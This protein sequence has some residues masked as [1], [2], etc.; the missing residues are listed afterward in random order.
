MDVK[1]LNLDEKTLA[2]L[3]KVKVKTTD[4]LLLAMYQPGSERLISTPDM[5]R[6]EKALKEAG[7][8]K[9]MR[10]DE[11]SADDID[12]EPLTWDELHDYVGK[13]IVNDSSTE[14]RRYLKAVWIYRIDDSGD[15]YLSYLDGGVS[16]CGTRKMYI[17]E[18]KKP[19]SPTLK[20]SGQFFVLK[21]GVQRLDIKADSGTGFGI[22]FDKEYN[23]ESDRTYFGKELTYDEL[24]ALPEGTKVLVYEVAEE[25]DDDD[26]IDAELYETEA[27]I[28]GLTFTVSRVD[29]D[30]VLDQI[31]IKPQSMVPQRDHVYTRVW[32]FNGT[33]QQS[34]QD[35]PADIVPQLAAQ[36]VVSDEYS[37]AI[38]LTR[39]II[40]NGQAAQQSLWE[41][42]KG[43]A[44][45]RDA[46]LYKEIGYSTF[47]DYCEEEIGITRRQG[48][49]YAAIAALDGKSTSDFKRIGVEKL[50][51]LAKIDDEQREQITDSVDVES[52]TVRELRAQIDALKHQNDQTEAALQDAEDRAQR[53]CENAEERRQ[54][55]DE[56]GGKVDKQKIEVEKLN[57]EV[58]NNA[59]YIQQLQDRSR[60]KDA[61]IEQLQARI[62]E[63]ESRPVEVAVQEDTAELEKLRAEYE[64]K[65]A[66]LKSDSNY[67]E[68]LA[69]CRLVR[70]Q[71]NTLCMRLNGVRSGKE[72]D[73]LMKYVKEIGL[74]IG[75]LL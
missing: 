10:G 44:E 69:M 11:V 22:D 70:S 47:E 48:Q 58:A 73:S 16:F 4:Q 12:P 20:Y 27:Q 8:I 18:N 25:M 14:S 59:S 66:E 56:L 42:C 30:D 34:D 51:L 2:R 38:A 55:I 24:T 50:Y 57:A 23:G 6:A 26:D 33:T 17:G 29:S 7:I 21:A 41:M 68:L 74:C 19:I 5:K 1:D 9:Y 31:K 62:A 32:L 71:V 64:K 54:R 61:D 39:S 35:A 49:K 53:W 46:K 67:T 37:R 65:I 28:K 75:Q 63:L 45:M 43:L 60:S 36:V 13:L 52:V 72:K 15:T 3:G 40:A